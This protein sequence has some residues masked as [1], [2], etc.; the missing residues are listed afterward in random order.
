MS[1]RHA[2]HDLKDGGKVFRENGLGVFCANKDFLHQFS[3]PGVL[4]FSFIKPSL[5]HLP[6]ACTFLLALLQRSFVYPFKRK[7]VPFTI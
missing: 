6:L 5:G 4:W 7:N 1:S 3:L 2:A